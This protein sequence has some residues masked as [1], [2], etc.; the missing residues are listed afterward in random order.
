MESLTDLAALGPVL[1]SVSVIGLLC[2][3][4]L[5]LFDK[6]SDRLDA[7]TKTIDSV[8]RNMESVSKNIEKNTEATERMSLIIEQQYNYVPRKSPSYQRAR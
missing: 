5:L 3:K 8:S 4:L 2:W 1:G 6:L 7:G